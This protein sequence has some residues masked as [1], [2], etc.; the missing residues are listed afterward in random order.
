MSS[1]FNNFHGRLRSLFHVL[2]D[3]HLGSTPRFAPGS[4]AIREKTS[5]ESMDVEVVHVDEAGGEEQ[6]PGTPKSGSAK[7]KLPPAQD[8]TAGGSASK[9]RPRR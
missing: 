5:S 6:A 1:S 9:L 4:L 7:R 8:E 3:D 2:S